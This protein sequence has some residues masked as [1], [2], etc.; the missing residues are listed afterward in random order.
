[1]RID[2]S[3]IA[4]PLAGLALL[5]G[6]AGQP[7]VAP[8]APM[9]I[10]QCESLA[11][12]NIPASAIG[13]PTRGAQVTVAQRAPE[14][15]PFRDAEGEHLL[16]TPSRCL[17]LATVLPMDPS[18]PPINIAVN[19][20]LANWN[21]RALQSGGGGLGGVVITAPGNKASGRF[22]PNPVN[23]PYPITQGYVTYGSD[24][25]HPRAGPTSFDFARTDE[26]VRNWAY[27][28]IKKTKDTAM[29]VIQAAYG[30]RPTH[31]FFSG[32]SAGGREALRAAQMFPADY[33]GVIAT[34]PV[35]SWYGIH[36]FDNY[37]RD[38]LVEGFLDA[39]AIKLIADRTRATCDAQDGL[40]DGV[41][42]K[43]LE[44]PNDVAQL[45]C[46]PAQAA[47]TCLT[48]AQVAAA[49]ALREPRQMPVP[50][51]NGVSRIPGF[52]VTGDEDGT[53]W[54]WAFYPI[55]TEAP[56]RPLPPGFGF[57]PRRGAILNFGGF[58]IRHTIVQRPDFDPYNF[59]ARP[60]ADR[61]MYL[62]R[63]FD[64]TDPDLSRFAARGGKLL[65]VHPSADN[66][67]PLTMSAE[68]YGSLVQQL[69]QG[70]TDRFMRLYVPAGGSHNVGGTSQVN[71][72]AML[73]DW[74]LRGQVPPDAPVAENRS[75]EN[76][77]LLNTM[78][79]CRFPAWPRYNG[80]G[81]PKI[82]T[83][84]T[85]VQRPEM[86]RMRQQ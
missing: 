21:G 76:A 28:E 7:T 44:C 16:P 22:D 53:G 59:D 75:I 73:E 58:L 38:R 77:A 69:G 81:D 27:E 80:S 32:E 40:R 12:M 3:G 64:A 8:F 31:V 23:V 46:T 29:A 60:Y 34:S 57:E 10:Q 17:V 5:A 30:R 84:F 14:V 6:C 67:A 18:A 54:Q 82:A 65:I 50:F 39:R 35:I 63:L 85:C 56:S 36:L 78:P 26:A 68:Y 2:S 51:A 61:I 72:L 49:N 66:A 52:G 71:A 33:D 37:V 42:A 9:A 1:M 4:L 45:Q 24:Q 25:G 62:S 15:A 55:G 48:P 20:P 83:S 11:G 86:V 47:G 19:L 70:A 41:V 13:L 79:A 43:Y 74:V